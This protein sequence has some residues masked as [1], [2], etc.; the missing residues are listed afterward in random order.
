[1]DLY[2][3]LK[4]SHGTKVKSKRERKGKEGRAQAT[5]NWHLERRKVHM[6][7]YNSTVTHPKSFFISKYYFCE[8]K[9][10]R[11]WS[12]NH[13]WSMSFIHMV[14]QTNGIIKKTIKK[15][16]RNKHYR[17]AKILTE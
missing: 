17:I 16:N 12:T 4:L 2:S 8:N 13:Q 6:A 10:S 14:C 1:L 5:H 15:L 3:E 7:Q 11:A 9:N